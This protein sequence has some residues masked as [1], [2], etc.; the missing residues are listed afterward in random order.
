MVIP[1]F[2]VSKTQFFISKK[3]RGYV[4][5]P[6]STLI[7]TKLNGKK[8]TTEQK[9]LKGDVIQVAGTSFEFS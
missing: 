1:G 7:K 6:Q 2:L 3:D 9:L 8:L 4:I 5:V